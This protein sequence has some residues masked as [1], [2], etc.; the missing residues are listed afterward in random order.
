MTEDCEA[1]PA[2]DDDL[3]THS[4]S[5]EKIID[6]EQIDEV[7]KETESL[8]RLMGSATDNPDAFAK[9][10]DS[11]NQRLSTLGT[12]H[13]RSREEKRLSRIALRSVISSGSDSTDASSSVSSVSFAP[14][15]ALTKE[16]KNIPVVLGVRRVV[17]EIAAQVEKPD[18]YSRIVSSISKPEYD[19]YDGDMEIL[20]ENWISEVR[21][22]SL[23]ARV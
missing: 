8:V 23:V 1:P 15:V 7:K 5:G 10:R 4:E 13:I 14:P 17:T 21:R 22:P 19:S 3:P 20:I 2:S 9:L 11:V 6:E 12:G 18:D 16:N